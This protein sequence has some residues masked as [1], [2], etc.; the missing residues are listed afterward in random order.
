MFLKWDEQTI[1]DFSD[2]NI[3]AMYNDGYVFGRPGRGYMNQTRSMRID[4]NK[5]ELSSENRRILRKTEAIKSEVCD[6]PYKNY[7][8]KIGKL[9]KDG[10][11]SANKI[12]ELLTTKHNFNKLLAYSFNDEIVGY[13]ICFESDDILHYSYPFYDLKPNT[14]NL[15]PNLG[16]SMMLNAILYAK[17]M[18]KQ[19]IY[20]GSAQRPGDTY[21]IQFKGLEWFDGEKWSEDLEELKGILK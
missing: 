6:V 1:T 15:I 4:L 13:T 12:K 14:Y 8:W 7:S 16:M 9:A 18:N 17:Q 5:F 10:T 19:Y 11:F 21:K 3:A 2:K 20:L